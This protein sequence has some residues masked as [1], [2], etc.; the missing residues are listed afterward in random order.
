[1]LNQSWNGYK[2]GM[3]PLS[4]SVVYLPGQSHAVG[5]RHVLGIDVDVGVD[6][7]AAFQGCPAVPVLVIVVVVAAS[8]LDLEQAAQLGPGGLD[9]DPGF[10]HG[11][12]SGPL[13]GLVLRLLRVAVHEVEVDPRGDPVV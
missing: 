3:A 4:V 11:V 2:R 6:V 10:L 13:E 1:M 5:G 8:A 12:L 7:A 9:H